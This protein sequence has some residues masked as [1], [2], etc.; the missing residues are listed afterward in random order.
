MIAREPTQAYLKD[1]SLQNGMRTVEQTEPFV[2]WPL[3]ALQR[4]L[5]ADAA[6]MAELCRDLS[7][8]HWLLD[9]LAERCFGGSRGYLEAQGIAD[10][11]IDVILAGAVG[12]S[13]THLRADVFATGGQ[14]KVIELNRGNG[15]G[16]IDTSL[17]NEALL[18][19][20]GFAAFARDHKLSYV[21]TL[22]R[23]ADQLTAAGTAPDGGP[24][25]VALI[26]ESGARDNPGGATERMCR[27]L[28]SRGLTIALGELRDLTERNGRIYL[29]GDIRVDVIFRY[30]D[31]TNLTADDPT[32]A[33]LTKAQ[34]CGAL[35][36]FPPLDTDVSARK[37]TLGLLREPH[38]WSAL[39]P[40]EQA[41]VDRRVPWT[42]MIGRDRQVIAECRSRRE[43]LVLKPAD[44]FQGSGVIIGTNVSDQEWRAHLESPALQN[45]LVQE[46]VVPDE[47]L[48]AD[49]GRLVD[50]HVLWGVFVLDDQYGGATLR[51]RPAAENGVIGIPGQYSRGCAFLSGGT[52]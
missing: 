10:E 18:G 29:N 31:A 17:L 15:L 32:T 22:Q 43:E 41:L 11:L 45:Y 13:C 9:D 48:F 21:D 44:G 30:F 47:E 51:G 49:S 37:A 2:S 42:R 46:R 3:Q 8:L 26:E 7:R 39:T 12:T 50:W 28:R 52:S 5:F 6:A 23:V 36:L 40:D 4:P 34:Y 20:P 14:A 19:Q 16:S 25:S 35:A 33:A 27:N 1:R 24:P 38:V